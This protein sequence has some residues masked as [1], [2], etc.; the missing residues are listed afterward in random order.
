MEVLVRSKCSV[1]KKRFNWINSSIFCNLF[2]RT[3]LTKNSRHHFSSLSVK[4]R[5]GWAIYNSVSKSSPMMY[6]SDYARLS[7]KKS[8]LD[9]CVICKKLC[10]CFL[11]ESE[12]RLV[13]N[14]RT[15]YLTSVFFFSYSSNGIRHWKTTIT[16]FRKLKNVE[17]ILRMFFYDG[18][19]RRNW[20][21]NRTTISNKNMWSTMIFLF[22][23]SYDS[24]RVLLQYDILINRFR[25]LND[26]ISRQ[27][28][29]SVPDYFLYHAVSFSH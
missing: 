9:I 15:L 18:T 8:K 19:S 20:T 29:W 21:S 16:I 23:Q 27:S 12:R 6:T 14:S 2:I 26:T 10:R 13:D 25:S 28:S 17:Y 22:L 11:R 24:S 4:K 1:V 5:K 7:V 3:I